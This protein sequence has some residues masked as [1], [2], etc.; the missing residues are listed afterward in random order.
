MML[1]QEYLFSKFLREEYV[2]VPEYVPNRE[3]MWRHATWDAFV[4]DTIKCNGTQMATMLSMVYQ[5]KVVVEMGLDAGFTTLQL[6]K[7]NPDAQIYGVDIRSKNGTCEVPIC[8]HAL[9]NNVKNLTLVLGGPSWKFALPKQVDFCF[10]DACHTDEAPWEDTIRA[11][12]NRNTSRDWCIAWD[13]YHPNNPDVK[14]AVDRFVAQVGMDLHQVG[15]WYYIGT[16]PHDELR[17]IGC[18]T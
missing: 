16:K 11:W 4:H 17:A 5:P 8:F 18:T 9:M 12:E 7:L 1:W 2:A 10:I 13:D 15:S 14:D 6:C 3:Y